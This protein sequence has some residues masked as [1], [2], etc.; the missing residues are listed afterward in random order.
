MSEG[1]TAQ[2]PFEWAVMGS[3]LDGW[4]SGDLHVVVPG[5]PRSLL[6]V[7]DGLGHGPDARRAADECAA[8]LRANAGAGL[9][10]L[11][12][13][14]HTGLRATRGVAMT[15][16][17]LD[18]VAGSL[19]WLA[20]GNVEGIVLHQSHPRSGNRAAVIQRGGVVG[21]RLPPLKVSRVALDPGDL[22]VFAT[23]GVRSNFAEQVDAALSAREIAETIATRF[24]KGSDDALVL[25]M[26]HRGGSL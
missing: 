4:A 21:Y 3:A 14:C 24:S 6:A 18:V 19:E 1:E 8:L 9:L 13:E 12:Q 15:I 10:E 16:A 17:H 11:V 7:I 26:R 23:D 25:V 20:V 22:I 2:L 5:S